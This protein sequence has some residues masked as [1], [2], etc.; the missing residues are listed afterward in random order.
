MGFTGI[1]SDRFY[2][3]SKGTKYSYTAAGRL[4]TRLWARGTNTTYAYNNYG[5]LSGVSYN[6]GAT[7]TLSYTYTRRGQ[8]EKIT[9]GSDSWKLFYTAAGQLLSEAGTAGT[10]QS[11][12]AERSGRGGRKWE[13]SRRAV[14]PCNCNRL[15]P[16]EVAEGEGNGK[17]RTWIYDLRGDF[18]ADFL[19]VRSGRPRIRWA[20]CQEVTG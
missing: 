16:S 4:S 13:E 8:Q 11:T 17:N 9:R 12:V 20:A 7:P 1:R 14:V 19:A 6:D 3:D 10:L 18:Q 2:D 5:D 15:S